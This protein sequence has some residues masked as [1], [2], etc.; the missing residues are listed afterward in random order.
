MIIFYITGREAV[1]LVYRSKNAQQEG[2]IQI[3]FGFS[4]YFSKLSL[5]FI[6]MFQR[7]ETKVTYGYAMK[8]LWTD[9]VTAFTNSYVIK[10][11]L[12][13][14]L[15]TCGYWQVLSYIQVL[16]QAIR[17]DINDSDPP[18]YGLVEAAYTLLGQF[19]YVLRACI[20]CYICSAK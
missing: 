7:T 19:N 1:K 15:A 14:A 17:K 13:W 12:W 20:L 5:N 9:F 4:G 8:H 3:S 16:F 10:W 6:L 18:L 2:E 11:A